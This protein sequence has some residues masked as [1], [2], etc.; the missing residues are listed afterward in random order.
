MLHRRLLRIQSHKNVRG[1][2]GSNLLCYRMRYVLYKVMPFGLKNAGAAYQRLFV[3]RIFKEK[4][5]PPDPPPWVVWSAPKVQY[6]IKFEKKCTFGV[7][8][9][10]FLGYL[11]TKR[12]IDANPNQIREINE[13]KSPMTMKEIQSL[14]RKVAALS[15]FLSR[16]TDKYKPFFPQ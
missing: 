3:N 6:E 12:G 2:H 5:R 7:A 9:G 16:S 4:I 10:K 11:V 14:T 8:L 1:G 15:R 13:M